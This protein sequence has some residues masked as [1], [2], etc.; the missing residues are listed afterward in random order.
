MWRECTSTAMRARS[1]ASRV[2]RRRPE[3]SDSV[4]SDLKEGGMVSKEK[5]KT[6]PTEK[7]KMEERKMTRKWTGIG[8]LKK[9]EKSHKNW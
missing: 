5:S 8:K 6:Q 4:I 1:L 9:G 7:G 2:A 3:S